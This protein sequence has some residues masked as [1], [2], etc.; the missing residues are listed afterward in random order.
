[1]GNVILGLLMLSPGTLYSLS[2]HFEQSISLFYSASLGSLGSALSSLSAR[3]LIDS[4]E[5]VER[6]RGKKTYSIT[7]AGRAAFI[8]WMLAPVT[9]NDVEK[10]ALA[11]LF[12]LGL[13]PESDRHTVLSLITT[14]VERDEA[15]LRAL[16]AHLDSLT[17]PAEARAIFHYQKQVLAYG[18]QAHRL[19]LD[20]FAA[21]DTD[22]G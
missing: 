21:V 6:G 19:S 20:F 12:F 11:K 3:G 8:E 13:L 4:V 1:M 18:L 9:Q 22:P 5:T 15:Q 14:R 2:K 10:I 16:S 17:V 7:D